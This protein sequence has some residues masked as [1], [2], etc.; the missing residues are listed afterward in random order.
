M[1]EP[2][3]ARDR[4][5]KLVVL[6]AA[7]MVAEVCAVYVLRPDRTLELYA[8][9]G[10]RRGAVH[11]TVLK[12]GEGLVGL[13]ASNNE[14]INLS[15]VRGHSAFSPR[16]E[17]GEQSY[18]SLLAVPIM[19]AGNTLGVLMVQNRVPR[20]YTEEEEEAL[21]TTAMVLA[22]MISS[23]ELSQ[24]TKRRR[25]RNK[26][27]IVARS[28]ILP[29]E[30]SKASLVQVKDLLDGCVGADVDP[31]FVG[32]RTRLP[33]HSNILDTIKTAVDVGIRI[34]Q[35]PLITRHHV[36]MLERVRAILIE[37]NKTLEVLNGSVSKTTKLVWGISKLATLVA[38]P[39]A[40]AFTTQLSSA[41]ATA[42]GSLGAAIIAC[43][44]ALG[45]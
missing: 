22:Q 36:T 16:P 27:T 3:S 41:V 20:T 4:L 32:N 12:A 2:V 1:A 9:E 28:E 18:R 43:R 23:G 24:P 7:N 17:T 42:I 21:Q 8:A 30:P 15:D 35:S 6:I 31:K 14:S 45:I 34:H 29:M 11:K 10:L 19:R 5:D 39:T 26:T 38:I 40:A 25:A 37:Y 13:V 44:V 33:I